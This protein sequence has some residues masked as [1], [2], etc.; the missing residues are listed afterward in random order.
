MKKLYTIAMA[1]AVSLTA[2]A[3]TNETKVVNGEAIDGNVAIKLR[4]AVESTLVL[5]AEA[6]DYGAMTWKS[7]GKGKYAASV[8]AD[9]YGISSAPAD[10]QVYESETTPGV[11][12]LVGVWADM[13]KSG[14]GTLIV[15]ASDPTF[16]LVPKQF[17]GIKDN[18]DGETYIASQTWTLTELQDVAPEVVKAAA[19]ELIPTMDVAAKTITFPAQ[20]LVLN[21]PNAPVDSKYGTDKNTWYTGKSAGYLVLPGGEYR[22]PWKEIGEGTMSGDFYFATFGQ[23]PTDYSVKVY[24]SNSNAN[25]YKVED[26]LKGLYNVLE[27]DDV[28]PSLEIDVTDPSNICIPLTV[29]GIN[30]GQTDGL[31][32]AGTV[33]MTYETIDMCP[34]TYRASF[35]KNAVE[36][37]QELVFSFPPK[38][39]LLFAS[40]SQKKYFGN[41]NIAAS[42]KVKTTESGVADIAI[43]DENAPVEYFNLQGVRVSEPAAGTLVIRRQG[44]KV[45]KV[46]VK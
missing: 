10:V 46:L 4:Q 7:L 2:A 19:S 3:N 1:A 40:A 6:P 28:S 21:W 33:N 35:S 27:F 26:A 11:Y 20:S 30:G 39:L 36:G 41:S 23:T 38:S 14:T 43:D 13:I 5:P 24:Q 22:D 42:L 15:D 32:Y 25:V 9:T 17:T 44:A 12:K 34:D 8:M 31:F 45:S 29:T 37:G 16:V 18:V